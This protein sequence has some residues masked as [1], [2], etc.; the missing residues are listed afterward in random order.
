MLSAEHLTVKQ[1]LAAVLSWVH[2]RRTHVGQRE[3]LFGLLALALG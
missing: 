1:L 2:L 3:V